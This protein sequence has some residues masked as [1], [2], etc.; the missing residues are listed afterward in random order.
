M[1]RKFHKHRKYRE[2]NVNPPRERHCDYLMGVLPASVACTRH[3]VVSW[4]ALRSG[5]WASPLPSESQGSEDV[6]G[7]PGQICKLPVVQEHIACSLHSPQLLRPL[8]S[9]APGSG[10]LCPRLL[11]GPLSSP[12]SL[13]VLAGSGPQQ[14][15]I[16]SAFRVDPGSQSFASY[17][18]QASVPNESTEPLV[19]RAGKKLFLWF[20][21]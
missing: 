1:P 16:S 13:N 2:E 17:N 10:T 4:G 5:C 20:L 21:S 3:A 11:G 7:S 8:H 6:R 18:L 9:F 12:H 14:R 15:C 19:Q